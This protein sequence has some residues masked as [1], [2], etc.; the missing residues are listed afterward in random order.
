MNSCDMYSVL[1][2]VSVEM[3]HC[4]PISVLYFATQVP[5]NSQCNVHYTRCPGRR[6]HA[7]HF[8]ILMTTHLPRNSFCC[9]VAQE[10]LHL[11]ILPI[12]RNVVFMKGAVEWNCWELREGRFR[13]NQKKTGMSGSDIRGLSLGMAISKLVG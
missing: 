13:K 3:T 6:F 1:I 10:L 5:R 4:I 11:L 12:V 9:D 8:C 2:C 7:L